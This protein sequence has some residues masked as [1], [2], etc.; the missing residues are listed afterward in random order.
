VATIL[1]ARGS[2]AAASNKKVKIST[3][4][5]PGHAVVWPQSAPSRG[6]IRAPN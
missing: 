3:A 4:G 2:I 1:V 6:G 5:K